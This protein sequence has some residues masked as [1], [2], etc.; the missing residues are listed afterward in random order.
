[1]RKWRTVLISCVVVAACI[2]S[3]E[4]FDARAALFCAA[5]GPR[6]KEIFGFFT[7]FGI[8]TP[9]LVAAFAGFIY[10]RFIRTNKTLANVAAFLFVAVAVSGLAN[11][12]IK[13]LVGRSRPG[14]LISR[15]IYSFKPF[16]I[17]YYWVSFPS[18]HSNTIA[19]LCY[20][21]YLVTGRFKYPL[22]LLALAVM[23]SRVIVDAHFPSDVLFGA[24][25]GVVITG[26]LAEDFEKRGLQIRISGN[27]EPAQRRQKLLGLR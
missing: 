2:T 17:H 7:R 21:L 14:L 10:F 18:G 26:L 13:F 3:Y 16:S 25:L 6:T 4:I 22:L 12:L 8:S 20:G 24:W 19:S 27:Q 5:L 15:G 11:D 9:Y 1:M 23:T